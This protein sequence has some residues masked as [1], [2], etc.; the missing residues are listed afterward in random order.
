MNNRAFEFVGLTMLAVVLATVVLVKCFE[1]GQN[2]Q[3]IK[4]QTEMRIRCAELGGHWYKG[5]CK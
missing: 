1:N 3:R 2:I 4:I 5:K